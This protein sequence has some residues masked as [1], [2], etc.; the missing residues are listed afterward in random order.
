M[1]VQMSHYSGIFLNL[2]LVPSP[3][4]VVGFMKAK[5]DFFLPTFGPEIYLKDRIRI[6]LKEFVIYRK[7]LRR[8]QSF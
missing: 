3:N 6:E 5:N 7:D 8:I 2:K 4:I 1:L